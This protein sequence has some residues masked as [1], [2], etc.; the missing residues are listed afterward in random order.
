M[1]LDQELLTEAANFL[2]ITEVDVLRIARYRW[3]SQQETLIEY[4]DLEKL[5]GMFMMGHTDLPLWAR[6]YI[7]KMVMAWEEKNE[8]RIHELLEIPAIAID[9]PS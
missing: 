8:K 2:E 7:R 4:E 6:D 1:K 3:Y 5:Y 9:E